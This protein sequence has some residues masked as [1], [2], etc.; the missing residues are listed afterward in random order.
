MRDMLK[1]LFK[2]KSHDPEAIKSAYY[3]SVGPTHVTMII[4]FLA[5]VIFLTITFVYPPYFGGTTVLFVSH[6]IAQIRKMCRRTVFLDHGEVKLFGDT[7]TV[8]N[9]Y[10]QML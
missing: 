8:C 4:S 7:E 1:Y 6:D 9:A 5:A 10:E 2:P 3:E